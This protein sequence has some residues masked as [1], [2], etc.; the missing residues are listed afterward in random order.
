MHGLTMVKC[1]GNSLAGE[2]YQDSHSTCGIGIVS[3]R[4]SINRE[5]QLDRKYGEYWWEPYRFLCERLEVLRIQSLSQNRTREKRDTLPVLRQEWVHQ[6]I[7]WRHPW[8]R[9]GVNQAIGW[10]HSSWWHYERYVHVL[11]RLLTEGCAGLLVAVAERNQP[12][13]VLELYCVQEL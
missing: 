6:N 9:Q 12:S 4:A 7:V 5:Y 8:Y 10:W 1:L 3:R 11:W 13:W 2:R